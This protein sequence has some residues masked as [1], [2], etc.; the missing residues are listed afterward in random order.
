MTGETA[1]LAELQPLGSN[2]PLNGDFLP[3]GTANAVALAGFERPHDGHSIAGIGVETSIQLTSVPVHNYLDVVVAGSGHVDDVVVKRCHSVLLA[4]STW[5]RRDSS[6]KERTF[7]K[8]ILPVTLDQNS[9]LV[10][11]R[12]SPVF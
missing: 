5:C 11:S 3:I 8:E 1:V 2:C 9:Q 12:G 4:G 6:R 7:M 10:G